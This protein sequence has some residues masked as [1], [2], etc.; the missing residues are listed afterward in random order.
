MGVCHGSAVLGGRTICAEIAKIELSRAPASGR[1]LIVVGNKCR[2]I[3]DVEGENCVASCRSERSAWIPSIDG[4]NYHV[5][6]RR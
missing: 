3:G 5:H 4:V 1:R 6:G 2:N